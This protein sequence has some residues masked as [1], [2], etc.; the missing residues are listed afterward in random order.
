MIR[1]EFGLELDAMTPY[2]SWSEVRA[3]SE[4]IRAAF[5]GLLRS[6]RLA[7]RPSSRQWAFLRACFA[8]LMDPATEE[9]TVEPRK[10]AQYKL[11]VEKRLKRY[12][13][14]AGP[15]LAFVFLLADRGSAVRQDLV[16]EDYPS[17]SGYC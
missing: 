7:A 9:V 13:H 11:E 12:Y 2:L 6:P 3:G 17:S 8:R 1:L 5:E 16:G 15:A 14:A 10:A 4:E